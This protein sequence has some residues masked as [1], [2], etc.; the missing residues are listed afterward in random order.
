LAVGAKLLFL[1]TGD[2]IMAAVA[3]IGRY[4]GK[5]IPKAGNRVI[6]AITLML[7]FFLVCRDE[8]HRA[9]RA[10]QITVVPVPRRVY[11]GKTPKQLM[12]PVLS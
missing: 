12:A 10:N 5:S 2:A 9:N 11:T 7:T 4:T 6:L 1:L 3:A 8:Y